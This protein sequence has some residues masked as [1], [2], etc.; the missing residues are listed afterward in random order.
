MPLPR[1]RDGR[2]KTESL[3][4]AFIDARLRGIRYV[5]VMQQ[6]RGTLYVQ[7]VLHADD[8]TDIIRQVRAVAL[9]PDSP[10]TLLYQLFDTRDD[11]H[12]QEAYGPLSSVG[13]NLTDEARAAYYRLLDAQMAATGHKHKRRSVLSRLFR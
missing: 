2:L 4:Q 8:C 12:V 6:S 1:E 7:T 3:K 11:F 9:H 10:Q 13:R 5:G